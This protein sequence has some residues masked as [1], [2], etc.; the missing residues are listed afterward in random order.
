MAKAVN[1]LEAERR[2]VLTGTPIVSDFY[3]N[4]GLTA[5]HLLDQCTSGIVFYEFSV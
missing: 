3:W 5:H 1:G 2:W 4:S